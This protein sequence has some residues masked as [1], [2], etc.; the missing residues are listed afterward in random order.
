MRPS[1]ASRNSSTFIISGSSASM[2]FSI[3]STRSAR[4]ATVKSSTSTKVATS[5]RAAVASTLGANFVLCY[6]AKN[7]VGSWRRPSDGLESPTHRQPSVPDVYGS[8][9]CPS[10]IG[11]DVLQAVSSQTDATGLQVRG[12]QIRRPKDDGHNAAQAPNLSP[13]FQRHHSEVHASER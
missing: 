11:A 2:I 3:S 5:V 4:P 6:C 13:L 12:C 8:A 1:Q 9:V 7:R 10:S